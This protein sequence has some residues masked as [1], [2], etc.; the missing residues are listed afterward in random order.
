MEG[1]LL[2]NQPI[3]IIIFNTYIFTGIE[4]DRIGI[5]YKPYKIYKTHIRKNPGKMTERHQ[6]SC[7]QR[8]LLSL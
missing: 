5:Y 3:I 8:I 7:T 1:L 6:P 2:Q 4:V